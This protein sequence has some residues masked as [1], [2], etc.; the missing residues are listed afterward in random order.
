MIHLL[1]MCYDQIF[2]DFMVN[3]DKNPE[4][5]SENC[6]F[7][8]SNYTFVKS[9]NSQKQIN[10]HK[11]KSQLFDLFLLKKKVNE[12]FGGI[13]LALLLAFVVGAIFCLFFATYV[14]TIPPE[15]K[16]FSIIALI[17]F[18]LTSTVPLLIV[19]NSPML[20]TEKVS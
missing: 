8:I 2:K 14:Y 11:I 13:I 17:F 10:F 18:L 6:L 15:H 4:D 7:L 1:C 19:M 5:E 9:N 12:Y 3:L 20:L 16:T